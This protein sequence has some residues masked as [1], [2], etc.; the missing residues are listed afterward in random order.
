[1][2]KIFYALSLSLFSFLGVN[3]L[4][5]QSPAGTVDIFCESF[6]SVITKWGMTR[7]VFPSTSNAN[8]YRDTVV[9]RNNSLGA[10]IDTVGSVGSVMNRVVSYLTSPA[11]RVDTF[12]NVNVSFNQICYVSSLDDATVE[13]SFDDGVTWRRL[14]VSTYTGGSL[15]NFNGG[16]L[17]FSKLSRAALWKFQDTSF[18]WTAT[19]SVAAWIREDFN[20]SSLVAANAPTQPG[21]STMMMIRLGLYDD[22][23]STLGREGTHA[24]YVDDFCITGGNCELVPPTLVLDDPPRNYPERYEERVYLNGPYIFDAKITDNSGI[25]DTGYVA[26]RVKRD[27]NTQLGPPE[28][29]IID[30][31]T[32]GMT[33]FSG[34][35]FSGE[36]PRLLPNGDSIQPGD[37]VCWKVEAIDGSACRNKSQDP[38]MGYTA[39]QV[40]PNL[41]KSCGTQPVFDYPYYQDFDNSSSFIAGS[42]GVLAE[43]WNNVSGDFH[44]WWVSQGTSS[45]T[46]KFRILDDFPG[47]GQYLYVESNKVS[48]GTYKDSAAFLLSPCFD[49]LDLPNGLVRFYVN[50]NTAGIEDSIRVDIFDPTPTTLFPDGQFV[51]NVIPAIRG[52]TGNNWLPFEFSTFPFRKTITQIRFV[53]T[54]GRDDGLSDIAIDSFKIIPA[55]LVDMRIN[56]INVAPFVPSMGNAPDIELEI[57]VQNLGVDTVKTFDINYQVC[58]DNNC[59]PISTTETWNGI[60]LPGENMNITLNEKYPA[61]LGIHE[62]KA[63]I[64]FVGDARPTNDTT[65]TTSRGLFYSEIKYMDDF[66]E[67]TLWTVFVEDDSLTNSWELGTPNYDYTNS[68]YSEPNSWDILLNRPYTG[69]GN[70][71]SL[72]S[73]FF[74]LTTA[75]SVILSFINNRDIRETKDGIFIEY[76]FDRGLSWDSLKSDHDPDRLR[77]LNS[78]LSAGGLGGTPVFAGNTFCYGNTWAGWLESEMLLPDTFNLQSEVL[79]RFNFFAEATDGGNDGMS[80]D[81]V[82]LY[83]PEPLDVQAQHFL[84]PTSQCDLSAAQRITTIFKN[85]G[86]NTVNTF[87]IEYRV[88]HVPTG[89]TEVKTDVVNRTVE[90]R[91]SIHVTSASVF[92]MFLTGDYF[93]EVIT[94]LPGDNCLENDTITKL[95]ENIE[96]CSLVFYIETSHRL[97]IQQPCDSSVWRFSYT[98]GGRDYQVSGAYNSPDY[99]INRP[100]GNIN[101]TVRVDVCM[102]SGSFVRFD[103]DDVDTLVS[104][105]SFIAYNGERDTVLFEEVAGGP[106]SPTQFFQWDCP[107][108]LSATPIRIL[109]D[110]DREQLPVARDYFFEVDILNN[111]L[112]SLDSVQVF[113]QIDNQMPLFQNVVYAPNYLEYNRKKRQQMGNGFLSPG[114]HEI[115][116]WT[117]LPN[118]K[119]DLLPGDDTLAISVTIMDTVRTDNGSGTLVFGDYSPQY[120][121]DFEDITNGIKWTSVNPYTMSQRRLSFEQGVPSSS[122]INSAN[123]GSI[124]WGTNIDGNYGNRDSTSLISPFFFVEKDSCYRISFMHNFFIT[125]S[126]SDGGTVQYLKPTYIGTTTYDNDF[127]TTFNN[128]NQSGLDLNG[129]AI[130]QGWYNTTHILSIPDNSQNSGWTGDSKGWKRAQNLLVPEQDYFTSLRWRFESN[131]S[132]N[133]DG[134]AIDDFCIENIDPLNCWAVGINEELFDKTSLYLGQNIPNPAAY[135]TSIPFYIPKAGEVEFVVVNLLGQPVYQ[136][137]GN[138]PTGDGLLELDLSNVAKGVYYY[139]M[140]FEG[141]RITNKMIIAK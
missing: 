81:N 124:A 141:N 64:N 101:D 37:T 139:T 38:M 121:E 33:R 73:P 53:G 140:T 114:T 71:V 16:D 65:A 5:A 8:F 85:R 7:T 52:N 125:D 91:D 27:T 128:Q 23:G 87:D 117:R 36:I 94:K 72:L 61:P 108:E 31:D 129:Q 109:I 130:E 88:T 107:P 62:I 83:D 118:G 46:G 56:A 76:S 132:R 89:N 70:T 100:I 69:T 113:L 13:Y 131:G 95:V 9:T 2:K 105:Y 84:S 34:G 122:V 48:S 102:K 82:L 24:W 19:N 4:S 135:S 66:D 92:D 127:W 110:S 58:Q 21:D 10:A 26:F 35:N 99:P 49:L 51:K 54:P 6:D 116:A 96:G 47:G 137:K 22:P 41:P 1:M 57:N 32:I 98:N 17:K 111:G 78:S 136:E 112:D 120:C 60:L 42:S 12:V 133:S 15:Y 123:S 104:N 30:E 50:L 67:D 119:Q 20:V 93:I 44:D 45:D 29:A 39:F 134:W 40:R 59:D 14:P 25:V 3:S 63:W 28:W 18:I 75:D 86:L 115:K 11:V 77:W 74:N 97:N 106:D 43:D 103:L 68:A 90:H 79:L 126:V 55:P 80:I 138:R